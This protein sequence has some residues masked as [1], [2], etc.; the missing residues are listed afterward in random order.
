MQPVVRSDGE[1]QKSSDM[2]AMGREQHADIDSTNQ[3]SPRM[4]AWTR[5]RTGYRSSE[6]DDSL[7][8][9]LSS[10]SSESSDNEQDAGEK[11]VVLPDSGAA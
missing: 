10:S 11:E 8:E 1:D 5:R 2:E 6:S 3:R 4:D 7:P 9:L